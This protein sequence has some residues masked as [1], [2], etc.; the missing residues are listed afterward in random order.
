MYSRAYIHARERYSQESSCTGRNRKA[1]S[2]GTWGAWAPRS[3][4]A[5]CVR[6]NRSSPFPSRGGVAV[7][8]PTAPR[9]RSVVLANVEAG[10]KLGEDS[11]REP[12]GEDVRELRGCRNM[13][14][15]DFAEGNPFSH[16]VKIDLDVL[17]ALMLD[18]IDGEVSSTD[19]VAIPQ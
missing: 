8:F 13:E 2:W 17:R 18:R 10:S 14:N 4:W 6:R 3:P 16:E 19:V 11:G 9:S 5:P 12:L 7:T 1:S 15:T